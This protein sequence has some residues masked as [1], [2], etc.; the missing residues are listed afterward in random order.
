MYSYLMKQNGLT[1]VKN[2][3]ADKL[4]HIS[5]VRY[6][7]VDIQNNRCLKACHCN[8]ES[9]IFIRATCA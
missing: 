2:A 7:L 8:L 6:A 4:E 3:F 9:L 5:L 1:L